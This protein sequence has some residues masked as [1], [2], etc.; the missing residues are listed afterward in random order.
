MASV[1]DE[2]PDLAT[3]DERFAWRGEQPMREVTPSG[4]FLSGSWTSIRDIWAHRQLWWRLTRRELKAR[5]KDSVLGYVWTLIR[6]LVNLLIYYL[7]IGKVLAAERAIPDFAVYV[8]AGLTAWTLFSQTITSATSSILANAGIVKKV[9]L[10]R[11]IFPLAATGSAVIDFLSQLVILFCGALL[12]RGIDTTAMFLYAPISLC[13]V[14]A[15]GVAI[16]LILS[17]VNVYLRDVQYLVEVGVLIGF[18]LTPCVYSYAQLAGQAPQFIT[19]VYLYNP[20]ALAVM[21]F[22]K[23]FWVQG[24]YAQWPV[25]LLTKLGIMFLIGIVLVFIAQRFFDRLQRNFAQEL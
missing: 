5:Y 8:F 2:R 20:M 9:Y 12:I 10:P 22:Q 6:P 13:V 15:W 25:H 23:A 11:E 16:G 1:T 24:Q 19:D 17:A 21:G 18:W 14:L 4:G 7:A 3:A